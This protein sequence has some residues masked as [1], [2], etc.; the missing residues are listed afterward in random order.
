VELAL[1]REL[2][3]LPAADAVEVVVEVE[4]VKGGIAVDDELDHALLAGSNLLRRLR[5]I[6]PTRE[7]RGDPADA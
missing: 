1:T 6:T 4:M 2:S 5:A 7:L 3:V